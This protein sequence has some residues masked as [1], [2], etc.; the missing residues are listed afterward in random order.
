MDDLVPSGDSS[1]PRGHP[2]SAHHPRI[3]IYIAFGT[4]SAVHRS[5]HGEFDGRGA[6]QSL[7]T[8]T[9]LLV[10]FPAYSAAASA[11]ACY[12]VGTCSGSLDRTS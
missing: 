6:L 11:S 4:S 5:H 3:Y 2:L 10:L 12:S 1:V 7:D 9:L 8:T